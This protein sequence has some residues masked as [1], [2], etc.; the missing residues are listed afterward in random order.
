MN[1][2]TQ[3]KYQTKDGRLFYDGKP[4]DIRINDDYFY[5]GDQSLNIY[6]E[7][8]QIFILK[9]LIPFLKWPMIS[10][11]SGLT[12]DSEGVFWGTDQSCVFDQ[13]IGTAAGR[14]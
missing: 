12:I 3:T 6:R 5:L 4:T 8:G 14:S 2:K 10:S 7:D 13:Y 1:M 9:R 11:P